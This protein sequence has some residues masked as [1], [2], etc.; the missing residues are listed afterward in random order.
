MLPEG[1]TG[2]DPSA[3]GE[4]DGQLTDTTEAMEYAADPLFGDAKGC[5]EGHTEGLAAG[6][7]YVRYKE[8]TNHHAGAPAIVQ[9]G[10]G[11]SPVVF[12]P[13]E[14][15]SGSGSGSYP[16]GM[17]VHATAHAPGEGYVFS[18][19]SGTESLTFLSGSTS[20]M[21]ISFSMPEGQRDH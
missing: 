12:H 20:D 7:Y 4:S 11:G 15:K 10:E 14:V 17:T 16:E 13:L 6:V 1:V 8:D 5:T 2:Q 3:E 21:E 19:W 9:I 18:G